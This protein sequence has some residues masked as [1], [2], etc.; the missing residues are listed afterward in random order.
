LLFNSY[1]FV[2]F[3]LPLLLVGYELLAQSRVRV[4]VP[5]FLV[6]G[7]L[8]FYGWWD[9]RYLLLFGFSIAFNYSW[10]QALRPR[11]PG[12]AERR[13]RAMLAAGV[14]VNVALLGY[15]KYRNFFVSSAA[16]LAGRHPTLPLLVLPLAIS[17]FTFEQLT[18]L[19]SAWRGEIETRDFL[20]YAL[21]ITFFPHLIAGPIVR[22]GEIFPQLNRTSRY[23]LSASNLS[24]GLMIFAIGLFKK[25]IIADTFKA[26]LDPVFDTAVHPGFVEAWAATLAFAFEIYFDFSGYSDMAIGLARMLNVRFPENFDSPYKARSPIEFWRRWH[27]TLS[28]F[29]R[30]YLYI[31]LGGNRRG[32]LR[33]HLNLFLTM[34]LGGLWHGADWTFVMWGA[35]HGVALSANHLWRDRKLSMPPALAWMLTFVF[36]TLAWVLFRAHSIDRVA[37]IFAGMTGLNGFGWAR[38]SVG[39]PELR[40]CA[41][42]L[43]LALACPNRQ[44]IMSWQWRSDYLYAAAFAALAGISLLQMS[45]P[46]PFIYFQ[47]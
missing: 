33:Q 14:A 25:V 17:F 46:P 36:V 44:T 22:Y 32:R 9:W 35:F 10:A 27:I 16:A 40:Q 2:F 30:D 43:V 21:F 7:S 45:N 29:L 18:Y 13:P 5:V 39:P 8:F 26:W 6:L 42:G 47:F 31:P 19:I 12:D 38:G 28:F 37:A 3:F 15:F 20:S 24:A 23:R 41:A 11:M 34:L 4:A 1:Q